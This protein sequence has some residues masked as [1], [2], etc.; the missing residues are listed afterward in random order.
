M[1]GEEIFVWTAVLSIITLIPFCF[2]IGLWSA[3]LAF[4]FPLIWIFVLE[5]LP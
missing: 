1:R 4:V 3:L 5:R 2:W